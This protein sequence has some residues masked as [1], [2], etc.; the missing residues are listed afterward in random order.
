MDE[1]IQVDEIV[2]DDLLNF[3]PVHEGAELV[4]VDHVLHQQHRVQLQ[5]RLVPDEGVLYDYQPLL[6]LVAHFLLGLAGGYVAQRGLRDVVEQV[7]PVDEG[8]GF[9]LVVSR[10]D[11]GHWIAERLRYGRLEKCS[12]ISLVISGTVMSTPK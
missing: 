1:R 9:V 7:R 12:V 6:R 4:E 10:D 5:L 11:L 3:L 8:R 2:D